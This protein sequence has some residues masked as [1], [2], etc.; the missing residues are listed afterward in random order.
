VFD[1]VPAT[2]ADAGRDEFDPQPQV[3][4]DSWENCQSHFEQQA[5]HMV[6][7]MVEDELLR[8]GKHSG[9]FNVDPSGG[10]AT[11]TSHP[12]MSSYLSHLTVSRISIE[13]CESDEER[14]DGNAHYQLSNES[15]LDGSDTVEEKAVNRLGKPLFHFPSNNPDLLTHTVE[16]SSYEDRP[17]SRKSLRKSYSKSSPGRY[18][19][20]SKHP[21][22]T[23]SQMKN[24]GS[25]TSSRNN[26]YRNLNDEYQTSNMSNNSSFDYL[27]L[28]EGSSIL[29]HTGHS[30]D[31]ITEFDILHDNTSITSSTRAPRRRI[32]RFGL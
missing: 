9:L 4:H 16:F 17:R 8:A 30:E 7:Q 27:P 32:R 6:E 22:H 1:S 20:S 19:V 28:A 26:M 11:S 21:S 12:T 29:A 5:E 3:R 15:D 31:N 25:N 10:S 14:N 18:N 23:S 24:D 2:P 13:S